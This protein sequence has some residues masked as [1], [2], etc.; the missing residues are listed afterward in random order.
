MVADSLCLGDATSTSD[1]LITYNGGDECAG[2]RELRACTGPGNDM[3]CDGGFDKSFCSCDGCEGPW[4]KTSKGGDAK[5]V[6]ENKKKELCFC[7]D[8]PGT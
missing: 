6:F 3:C 4:V 7:T 8:T 2:T 5:K 1:E